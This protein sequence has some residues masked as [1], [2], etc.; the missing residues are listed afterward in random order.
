M[1]L[2]SQG[3]PRY[4]QLGG[5]EAGDGEG[6]G[7]VTMGSVQDLVTMGMG[8]GELS[9][10]MVMLCRLTEECHMQTKAAE[11]LVRELEVHVWSLLG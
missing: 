9:S 8:R 5:G 7:V 11:D 2:A 6:R 1:V 10:L 4:Q 3:T